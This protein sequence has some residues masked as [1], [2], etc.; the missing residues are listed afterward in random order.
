MSNQSVEKLLVE[1]NK[2]IIDTLPRGRDVSNAEVEFFA[3]LIE[4]KIAPAI[5]KLR[6][7]A[8]Q[9]A[10][11]EELKELYK[12]CWGKHPDP[13]WAVNTSYIGQIVILRIQ[14]LDGKKEWNK[15]LGS[16]TKVD[17]GTTKP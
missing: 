4:K 13:E 15:M 14:K 9:E 7:Q 5:T 1:L 8:Q 6:D 16:L 2:Y 3:T 10:R 12:D 17:G 11:V